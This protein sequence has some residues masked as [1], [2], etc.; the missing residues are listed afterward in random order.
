VGAEGGPECTST[1]TI[2][3]ETTAVA[4]ARAATAAAASA[5]PTAARTPVAASHG[6]P[7]A[8]TS[9]HPSLSAA[10]ASTTH[11]SIPFYCNHGPV[12]C[13]ARQNSASE[14][15]VELR[16]VWFALPACLVEKTQCSPHGTVQPDS[17]AR[18]ASP[19]TTPAPTSQ[20]AS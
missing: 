9:L 18:R 14:R 10:G 17:P 1:V 2:P 4:T 3:T 11:P 7:R 15:A 12:G 5:L 13:P 6:A 20:S 19:H 8:P 16:C